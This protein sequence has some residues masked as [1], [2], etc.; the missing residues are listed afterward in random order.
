[1]CLLPMSLLCCQKVSQPDAMVCVCVCVSMVMHECVLLPFVQPELSAGAQVFSWGRRGGWT[2]AVAGSVQNHSPGSGTEGKAQTEV[3][4]LKEVFASQ[5]NIQT[6]RPE[7]NGALHDTGAEVQQTVTEWQGLW[8]KMAVQSSHHANWHSET[9]SVFLHPKG[10]LWN[11]L[12]SLC[13]NLA[14]GH[15]R[16]ELRMCV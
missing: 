6:L 5:G 4:E 11:S 14:Q 2:G 9:G 15:C 12:P 7:R 16:E 3:S 8:L 13:L 10:T 1:M